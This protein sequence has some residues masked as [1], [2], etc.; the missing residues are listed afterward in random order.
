MSSPDSLANPARGFSPA[1]WLG[2]ALAVAG[3]MGHLLAAQAIGGYWI[4]YRDHVFGFLLIL[5]VTGAVI[6][7]LGAR[8]W[9]GRRD[10]TVLLIGVVQ[11]LF[12]FYVYLVRFRIG[13][14]HPGQ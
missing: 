6:A 10:R 4:A 7:G 13:S 2:I 11:A 14:M 12:G 5:V 1:I 9:P 8:F 3:L